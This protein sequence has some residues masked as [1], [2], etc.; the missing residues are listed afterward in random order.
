MRAMMLEYVTIFA[1]GV[2]VGMVAMGIFISGDG[3][4]SGQ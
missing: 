2:F 4:N 3:E 1:L